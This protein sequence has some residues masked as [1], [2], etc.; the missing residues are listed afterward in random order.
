MPGG[1]TVLKHILRNPKKAKCS[2]CGD[3]LKGIARGR[4]NQIRKLPKTK[5]TVSR[6]YGGNLCSKCMR[7]T[8]KANIK[9]E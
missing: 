6:P 5:K 1:K 4:P 2:K 7:E 3:I 8:I 9:T